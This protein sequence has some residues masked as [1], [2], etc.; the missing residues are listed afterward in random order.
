[1]LKTWKIGNFKSFRNPPTFDLSS[2]NILAGANSSGKSSLIQSILLLKQTV[3]YG[4]ENRSIALNGPLLRMGEFQDVRNFEAENENLTISFEIEPRRD[5]DDFSAWSRQ[6]L[7]FFGTS[8]SDLKTISLETEFRAF[9]IQESDGGLR[10]GVGLQKSTLSS[11]YNDGADKAPAS[12]TLS[13]VSSSQYQEQRPSWNP[14]ASYSVSMDPN[15][16]AQMA[17]NKPK[18]EVHGAEAKHFLPDLL[19]VR[20]DAAAL[21]ASELAKYIC[22]GSGNF[23]TSNNLANEHI[24]PQVITVLNDFIKKHASSEASIPLGAKAIDVRRKVAD[25]S[26]RSQLGGILST[27]RKEPQATEA[28]LRALVYDALIAV[29][30]SDFTFDLDVPRITTVSADYIR[31][32]FKQGVRYLGPLRDAPRP[33]YP[34]EALEGTT[35][36]GYRGEHTAAVFQLNSN[37]IVSYHLPPTE[38]FDD[39]YVTSASRKDD[40]LHDA[41]VSWLTYLGVA[42]EV[43]STDLGV[44]GNRLQVATDN[45]D[46]WHDLTNVGVGVSQVLPL[47]VTAL[48]AKPGSLLVFEQPELHLHPRVQARLA[49]FFLALAL[50]GKQMILETHSE[51]L[52]DRFRLRIAL[53]ETDAVRPLLRMLFTEK[54]KGESVVTPVEVTEFGAIANWPKDFF[55]QSQKDVARLLKAAAKRRAKQNQQA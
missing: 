42:D 30:K 37:S 14:Y 32:F 34:L 35:E 46:R 31:D 39:D 54:V 10:N 16:F 45:L 22:S 5:V 8:V 4:A 33:V 52:I 6:S 12:V 23:L 2:I 36:V 41:A 25:I 7:G 51:Y 17:S 27:K 28:F 20:Y 44:F 24:E 29:T 50:D 9:Y 47:V 53:S 15:S 18:L 11:F 40:S 43:K 21:K 38:S 48:L 1:M 49:D 26:G 13:A 3:Q 19:L 55:D